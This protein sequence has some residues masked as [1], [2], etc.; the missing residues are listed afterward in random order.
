MVA[1]LCCRIQMEPAPLWQDICPCNIDLAF[2]FSAPFPVSLPSALLFHVPHD[3]WGFIW[4]LLLLTQTPTAPFPR[5][6][7]WE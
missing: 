4:D 3:L 7:T 1:L 2:A 6:Q 5:V